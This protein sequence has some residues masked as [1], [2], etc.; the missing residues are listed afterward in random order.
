MIAAPRQTGKSAAALLTRT[1]PFHVICEKLVLEKKEENKH[2]VNHIERPC[3]T[4]EKGHPGLWTTRETGRTIT[5]EEEINMD[6]SDLL[7]FTDGSGYDHEDTRV[8]GASYVRMRRKNDSSEFQVDTVRKFK[9]RPENTVFQAEALAIGQALMDANK[10]DTIKSITIYSDCLSAVV[11]INSAA[12]DSRLIMTCKNVRKKLER[13]NI[14]VKTNHIK[15]HT[16]L[17]GNELA[18]Q[19]AKDAALEGEP[20]DLPISRATIKRKATE[21]AN[22]YFEQW[23]QNTDD[24]R[25]VKK[26]FTGPKDNL[27]KKAKIDKLTVSLYSGHGANLTSM[28]YGF[29]G[30]NENCRCG[31]EQTM[32]H[33]LFE[34]SILME[35]NMKTAINAGLTALE[36]LEPWELKRKNNKIHKYIE[37]R[38]KTIHNEITTMNQD[39]IKKHSEEIAEWR[40]Q[41]EMQNANN[42]AEGTSNELPEDDEADE[43]EITQ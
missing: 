12:P 33:L 40:R 14:T 41:K 28:R 1:L 42:P 15:A 6:D 36:F 24:G 31:S 25:E 9:L 29:R 11:G 26:Y 8:V 22:E 5:T 39:Y 2:K 18:D 27:L 43:C 37:L 7:Y 20:T 30:A 13:K 16:G 38:S 35:N 4:A 21:A 34:C 19:A 17:I 23:Y 32:Q 3:T 10:L